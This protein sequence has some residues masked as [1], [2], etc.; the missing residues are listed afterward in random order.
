MPGSI[1]G[2]GNTALAR[3][4]LLKGLHTEGEQ[5]LNHAILVVLRRR[6]PIPAALEQRVADQKNLNILHEWL[7]LTMQT[8]S[9]EEF[10]RKTEEL[11]SEHVFGP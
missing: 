10:A 1:E 5:G 7:N 2:N 11:K 3:W 4:F 9:I 6:G 8:E